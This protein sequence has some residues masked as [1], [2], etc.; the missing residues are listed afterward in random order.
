MAH[1]RSIVPVALPAAGAVLTALAAAALAGPGGSGQIQL[2]AQVPALCSVAVADLGVALDL[3]RPLERVAVATVEERCNAAGGYKVSVSTRNGGEL[4][5]GEGSAVP[6][7]LEYDGASPRE[8][9]LVAT[10]AASP[11]PQSRELS[12]STAPRP[13][14]PAG[15]YMDT[16]TVTISG[17]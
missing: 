6:Y 1:A 16:V 8:G 3:A 7:R 2:R 13:G 9:G 10:R 14:T 4:R 5:S 15:S 11:L 17:E 12:V